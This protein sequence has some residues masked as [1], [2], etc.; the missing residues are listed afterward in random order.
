MQPFQYLLAG[1][2]PLELQVIRAS[3]FIRLDAQEYLDFEASKD[4]LRELARACQKRGLDRALLDLRSLPVP[5]K[6]VF[7]PTELALLVSTFREAGFSRG[8][9]LAILYEHDIYGGVR[10]FAFISRM[11]G[12][13]V[14]AFIGFEHAFEWLFEAQQGEDEGGREDVPVRIT[15]TAGASKR[16]GLGAA[17]IKMKR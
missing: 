7:T 17:R 16:I 4:A 14:Q 5:T 3:E 2:M 1:K 15:R 11:R 8:Q 9:R 6:R 12:M 10:N 13:D